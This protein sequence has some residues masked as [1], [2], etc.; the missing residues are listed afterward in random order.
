MAPKKV[1]SYSFPEPIANAE[2]VG[3][4]ATQSAFLDAWNRRDQYP[5][6]PVWMLS[7]VKGIGKATLAYRIARF[8]FGEPTEDGLFESEVIRAKSGDVNSLKLEDNNLKLSTNNLSTLCALRTHNSEES[9]VFHKMKDGGFG[10]FFIIDLTHN[11]DKDGRP[12]PDAKQISVH[13]IRAMIEKMQLSSMEGAW[14]V[15]II[16]S[17]DEMTTAASNAILKL[18]EE[19]PAKT[20]FLLIVHSLANTLPT[21]RSRAR[22]EKLHPLSIS[23]LRD[24]ARMFLPPEEQDLSPALLRLANGSFGRIANLIQSGGDELYEELLNIC[25]NPRA[26]AADVMTMASS[27]AKADDMT[28]ILLDACAHFG[29]RDLYPSVAREIAAI[30]GLHLEPEVA[31]F[32]MINEIRKGAHNV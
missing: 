27:I 1:K 3:H 28:G 4:A 16:D 24:V 18:L 11:V 31:V 23:E 25:E 9:G 22:V 15:V 7:G 20:L 13:T 32:R 19:P 30:D 12:K 17:V 2:L 6:H 5:V 26:N 8:V 14:R 21:I 29:L 10:D